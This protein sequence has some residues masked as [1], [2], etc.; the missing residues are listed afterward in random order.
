MLQ[1]NNWSSLSS[2]DVLYLY[3]CWSCCHIISYLNDVCVLYVYVVCVCVYVYMCVRVRVY[4]WVHA[5][6]CTHVYMCVCVSVC[7][8][9]CTH[10]YYIMFLL[11]L[12]YT[13]EHG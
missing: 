8:C 2:L 12:L 1:Y 5:Y 6:V 7:V 3:A 10:V 9:M 11:E 13:S 4:T